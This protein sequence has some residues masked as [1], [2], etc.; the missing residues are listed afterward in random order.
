MKLLNDS[1]KGSSELMHSVFPV[2][3]CVIEALQH[4]RI[5]DFSTMM[6]Y[7][8]QHYLSIY[9]LDFFYFGSVSVRFLK[10]NS[11]LVWNQ[12]GLVWF[13]EMRFGS[14]VIVE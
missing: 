8:N 4:Q 12:F 9:L 1:I 3:I 11:D 14:D 13:E 7:I 10:K 2:G 6:H 5:R